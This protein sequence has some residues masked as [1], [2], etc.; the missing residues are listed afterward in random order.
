MNGRN[1]LF[2]ETVPTRHPNISCF[3]DLHHSDVLKTTKLPDDPMV[4]NLVN[5]IEKRST[6]S[7]KMRPITNPP[8][9]SQFFSN[10]NGRQELERIFL[11]SGTRL[12]DAC[13]QFPD[14]FR[15]YGFSAFDDLGFG[16]L[17]AF[18][19]NCPNTSPPSLWAGNPWIPL[20]PRKTN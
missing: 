11:V 3:K 19:R 5:K 10:D 12:F 7:L 2:L 15:P 18:Y 9:E 4:S 16:S 14:N 20:F 8:Y 6:Y 17:L 13:P 1:I